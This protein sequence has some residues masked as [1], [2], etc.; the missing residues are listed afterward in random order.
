MLVVFTELPGVTPVG[1]SGLSSLL[2]GF[3][4]P[5]LLL[6][7]DDDDAEEEDDEEEDFLIFIIVFFCLGLY[8][9]TWCFNKKGSAQ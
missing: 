9:F 8:L 4:N 5:T 7:D 1:L 2:K 3:S 6:L